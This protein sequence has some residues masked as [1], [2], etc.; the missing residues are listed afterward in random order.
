MKDI[1]SFRGE[2]LLWID[3][4]YKIKKNRK[5]VWIVLKPIIKKYVEEQ[6]E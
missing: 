6:G 3:F 2:R 4:V 1:I 5:K